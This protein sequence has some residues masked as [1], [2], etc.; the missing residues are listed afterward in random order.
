M[1][2][3]FVPGAGKTNT[4]KVSCVDKYFALAVNNELIDVS[5]IDAPPEGDVGVI[6]VRSKN[7][8]VEPTRVRFDNFK[9]WVR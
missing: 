6:A 7:E 8:E 1:P 3:S 4:I 9:V 2:K 5:E